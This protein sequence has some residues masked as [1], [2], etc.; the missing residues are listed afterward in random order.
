MYTE[1]L[2]ARLLLFCEDSSHVMVTKLMH[3]CIV[4]VCRLPTRHRKC[5]DTKVLGIKII[6]A[7]R[8]RIDRRVK[9]GKPE[10]LTPGDWELRRT[11]IEGQA[12]CIPTFN[13]ALNYPFCNRFVTSAHG[14]V[15]GE[16]N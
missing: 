15:R 12:I 14:R 7:D 10:N 6:M 2:P 3:D 13:D 4:I 1:V 11:R 5:L 9:T 16:E 8:V